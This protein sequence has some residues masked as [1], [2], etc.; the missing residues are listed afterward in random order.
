MFMH[1]YL[2]KELDDIIL[3]GDDDTKLD[4]NVIVNKFKLLNTNKKV[5]ETL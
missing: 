1:R 3:S 5:K 4:L 2:K